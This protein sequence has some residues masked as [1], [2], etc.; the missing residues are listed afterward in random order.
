[1]R[2][3]LSVW[4]ALSSVFDREYL[5]W[6]LVGLLLVLTL[7]SPE[8]VPQHPA[9]VDWPTIAALLGLLIVTKGVEVIG[10][11]HGLA[12]RVL[13]H[14]RSQRA[15]STS[16]TDGVEASTFVEMSTFSPAIAILAI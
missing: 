4:S 6:T 16:L 9:L 2:K 8:R 1:V 15:P 10:A 13:A 3:Y 12:H 7:S 14:L 5:F 11:L